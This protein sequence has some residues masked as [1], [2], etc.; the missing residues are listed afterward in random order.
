MVFKVSVIC[1][2]LIMA[3]CSAESPL[4]FVNAQGKAPAPVVAPAAPE[5]PDLRVMSFN[6]RCPTFIDGLNYW[7]FRKE[8]LVQTVRGFDPDVLGTQECVASQAD[9]LQAQLSDYEFVGAG[10]DD[11][12]RGGEM[13]GVFFRRD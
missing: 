3:G 9:Y 2:I 7:P 10:R 8:L 5:V 1:L 12:K 4:A 6:L 13:C 11:G